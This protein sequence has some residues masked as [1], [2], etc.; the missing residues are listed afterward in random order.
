MRS[1]RAIPSLIDVSTGTTSHALRLALA[2]MISFQFAVLFIFLSGAVLPFKVKLSYLLFL[3]GTLA[4]IAAR[5]NPHIVLVVVA[6]GLFG[7]NVL[8]FSATVARF[9]S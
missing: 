2:L 7:Y 8:V 9:M 5:L 6:C 1:L 4:G 3:A